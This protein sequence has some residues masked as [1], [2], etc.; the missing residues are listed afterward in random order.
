MKNIGIITIIDYTNYGNRLQNYAT[1][2]VLRSLGFSV[3]TI[4]NQPQPKI[5]NINSTNILSKIYKLRKFTVKELTVKVINE[6][7]LKNKRKKLINERINKFIEFTKLNIVETNYS[8]SDNS[9]PNELLQKFDFFITGSDQVWNPIFRY[10]SS[11]D[12]LTF[13]EKNK[14]VAY[15]PSF[16]ISEIPSEF[17]ENYKEWLLEIASLSI[18]EERGAE[19]IKDLT[20]RDAVVLVDPTLMLSK[21]KWLSVSKEDISKPIG[22]YLLT[23]FLGE[24]S[25]EN[26]KIINNIA[27]NNNLQ[28]INLSSIK[29][30]QI[31]TAGPS[32]FIDY[33]N[34]AS[35]FCTDSFHGCVFSILLE[36]PFIVFERQG[37]IPSMNSRIDTLL[38]K[39]QLESRRVE[40]I[41]D[42]KQ[43]FQI[44]Y[45]HIPPILEYERK[46]AIKYLKNALNVE[47]ENKK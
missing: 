10:G 44:D 2:E 46:K 9:I 30:E 45:S 40:N 35:I 27:K 43:I 12:F 24:V 41:K 15:A 11:I 36:R 26:Q 16:G 32:E 1:Q 13:A 14:R 23:Y 47:E 28:V 31:Y 17:K 22:K 4:I 39:F 29:N 5:S 8:I 42:S 33:I 6:T 3:Q 21:E 19:I 25:K 7:I 20:N 38:S 18:R 37:K 34:S